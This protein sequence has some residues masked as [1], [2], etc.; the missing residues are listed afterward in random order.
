[1]F[2]L[3]VKKEGKEVASVEPKPVVTR[4]RYSALYE[5]EHE[6]GFMRQDMAC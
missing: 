1:M 5:D 4:N 6:Q 2:Y 3:W